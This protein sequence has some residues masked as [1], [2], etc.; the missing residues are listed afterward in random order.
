VDEFLLKLLAKKK[1]R[2]AFELAGVF[3]TE[4]TI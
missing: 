1:H 4:K 2:Q 3:E